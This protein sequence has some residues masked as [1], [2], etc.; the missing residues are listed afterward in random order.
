MK[1]ILAN[2]KELNPIVVIGGGRYV[3]GSK[4]DTLNF[5]F[6]ENT[7][8]DELDSIFTDK[9]CETIKIYETNESGAETEYIHTGYIIRAELSRAPVVVVEA[10]DTTEEVIENRVTVSMAQCTY[11]EKQVSEQGEVID[12]LLNGEE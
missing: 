4:R 2:G 10:T 6:P 8:L 12:Y 11:T 7:S 3:S 9:N 1:I 5:I